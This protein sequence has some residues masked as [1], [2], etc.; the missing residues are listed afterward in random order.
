MSDLEYFNHRYLK[1]RECADVAQS[2]KTRQIHLNLALRYAAKV[3]SLDPS[4]IAARSK[5]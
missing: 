4:E 5:F 2:K 3:A 1:Q